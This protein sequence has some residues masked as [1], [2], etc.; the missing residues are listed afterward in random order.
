MRGQTNIHVQFSNLGRA[1]QLFIT[2]QG[3][4]D[5]FT[6][7]EIFIQL[8]SQRYIIAKSTY[9]GL[10][11]KLSVIKK[12]R[13]KREREKKDKHPGTDHENDSFSDT[14]T[15][16]DEVEQKIKKNFIVEFRKNFL[17]GFTN[18]SSL[19]RIIQQRRRKA[20]QFSK[21]TNVLKQ[22]MDKIINYTETR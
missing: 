18:L 1:T 12:K 4:G 15:D 14:E 16:L 13:Q 19:D 10:Y 21:G 3:R 11:Q 6:K 2:L 7:G 20:I 8:S 22:N 17:K 9:Q 5:P